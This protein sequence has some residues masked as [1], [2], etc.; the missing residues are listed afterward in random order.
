M[1]STPSIKF[2][3]SLTL[4]EIEYLLELLQ[5]A[6]QSPN[7][8]LVRKLN[9]FVLKARHGITAPSHATIGQQSIESRLGLADDNRIEKLLEV[10][11]SNP[12]VLSPA[13]LKRVHFY[14]FQ[15][16]LMTEEEETQYLTVPTGI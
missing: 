8:E 15:N 11:Q 12:R 14:R 3:P 1:A 5:Q 2:R 10:Y 16:D 6:G 7:A 9:V 4:P 13:Q